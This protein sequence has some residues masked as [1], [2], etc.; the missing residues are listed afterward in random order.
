M[1]RGALLL[2][3]FI[4]AHP[5]KFRGCCAL[6]LGSGTGFASIVL[7]RFASK[8]FITGTS[9]YVGDL[10][11]LFDYDTKVLANCERNVKYNQPFCKG[12][13]TVR[14]LDWTQPYSHWPFCSEFDLG[15]SDVV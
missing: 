10:T 12:T 13:L 2:G 4:L 1:W 15:T 7:G 11:V 6:E 5:D 8:V 3:D 14:Q 9:D